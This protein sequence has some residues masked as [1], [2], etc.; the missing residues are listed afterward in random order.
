[1]GRNHPPVGQGQIECSSI[2]L[3]RCLTQPPG[4]RA[5]WGWPFPAELPPE[6]PIPANFVLPRIAAGALMMGMGMGMAGAK[7]TSIPNGPPNPTRW[8]LLSRHF[9]AWLR[10]IERPRT[11]AR[12]PQ[13]G[14][15]GG[16]IELPAEPPLQQ[17]ADHQLGG[18]A[19]D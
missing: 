13:L 5:L 14:V 3:S 7:P 19:H 12:D 4:G 16:R 2:S 17:Q 10:S 8:A 6:T 9:F 1:M 11:F 18:G 15:A